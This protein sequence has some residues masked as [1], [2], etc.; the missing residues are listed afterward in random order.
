MSVRV[1]FVLQLFYNKLLEREVGYSM[2]CRRIRFGGAFIG[3]C[4][5][6]IKFVVD[7]E[8]EKSQVYFAGAYSEI[9]WRC[10]VK[11]NESINEQVALYS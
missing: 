7:M 2:L 11:I 8:L 1:E 9:L 3:I 4:L 5:N 6:F 10:D